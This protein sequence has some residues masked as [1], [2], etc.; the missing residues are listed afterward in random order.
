MK[1][2]PLPG[3]KFYSCSGNVNWTRFLPLAAL[4]LCVS[5]LLAGFMYLLFRWGHYYLV[6]VPLIL[7]LAVGG[8][9]IL[10]ARQGHCRS[11][12]IAALTGLFCGFV[13]YIGYFYVGMLNDPLFRL[14][15]DAR[16]LPQYVRY[17]METDVFRDS[18]SP[19]RDSDKDGAR[20][21]KSQA[22][23]HWFTF[24]FE[25]LGVLGIAAAGGIRWA[26][27]PYC[28]GCRQWMSRELTRFEPDKLPALL[29]A[30]K[31]GPPQSLAALFVTPPYP[32]LP[33]ATLAVDYCP[34][35]KAAQWRSCPIFVSLKAV[36]ANPKGANLDA[37]DAAKGKPEFRAL[38]LNPEELLALLPRFPIFEAHTGKT[39]AA[40]LQEL[41]VPAQ[42]PR[43]TP[44][45]LADITPV[46]TEYAGR[47]LTRRTALIGT[48]CSLGALALLL[49]ALGLVV[50]CGI[51]AFPEKSQPQEVAPVTKALALAGLAIGGSL[52]LGTAAFFF[53]NP[54]YFGNHYLLNLARREFSRRPTSLVDSND[55]GSLFVEIVPKLHWGKMKLESASDVGFLLLHQERREILFEGDREYYRIPAAAVTSCDVEFFVA[56]E[57]SH[58]ATKIFFVVLRAHHPT[59]FWEAPI[60]ARSGTGMFQSNKRK[61]WA[62]NLQ[63][64][65]KAM[66]SN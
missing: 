29:E 20:R 24:A 65:I 58:A 44:A 36:R 19:S 2:S 14:F 66:Q 57:G 23:L 25:F 31:N 26:R 64:E 38:H 18:H 49:A 34:S 42:P 54:S 32:T 3:R 4:A 1:A 41:R 13:L 7:G 62:L 45:A 56:G 17:R 46:A 43:E 37:F 10:A 48:A 40:A 30:F 51:T 39:A 55:P 15:G 53:I 33:N 60:R 11:R 63:K 16:S 47:V 12:M 6:I 8:L 9:V 61:K 5:G 28:E 21:G 52:F 35:V 59:A 22:W 27:K 50:W